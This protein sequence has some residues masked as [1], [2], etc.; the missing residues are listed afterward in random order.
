MHEVEA[1]CRVLF[2]Q[3]LYQCLHGWRGHEKIDRL[4]PSS[5]SR[6][7][8]PIDRDGTCQERISNIITNLRDRKS[9]CKDIVYSEEAIMQLANTPA[10]IHADRARTKTANNVRKKTKEKGKHTIDVLQDHGLVVTNGQT[11]ALPSKSS[12][13]TA[14][15]AW[16][17][18]R[19]SPIDPISECF[20]ASSKIKTLPT[21]ASSG[22]PMLDSWAVSTPENHKWNLMQSAPDGWPI[23]NQSYNSQGIAY[24]TPPDGAS[25]LSQSFQHEFGESSGLDRTQSELSGS[26]N[27]HASR[28]AGAELSSDIVTMRNLFDDFMNPQP[29]AVNGA[30]DDRSSFGAALPNITCSDLPKSH[31]PK[32]DTYTI[33]NW[34]DT[35]NADLDNNKELSIHVSDENTT[36]TTSFSSQERKRVRTPNLNSES[37]AMVPDPKRCRRREPTND[38]TDDGG[39]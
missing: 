8:N 25:V 24:G 32:S 3:V 22:L 10:T 7:P 35:D 28:N 1:A 36:T 18:P 34:R 5:K 23:C 2:N 29:Y 30:A 26:F 20:D 16:A 31:E 4:R 19:V 39:L 33:S 38:D 12:T 15:E 21:E 37:L 13:S 6:C 9:V 27:N 17:V 11:L 14:K